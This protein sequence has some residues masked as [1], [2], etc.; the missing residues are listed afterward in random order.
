MLCIRRVLFCFVLDLMFALT[1]V[2]ISSIMS[3]VIVKLSSISCIPFVKLAPEAPGL[4]PI[5]FISRFLPIW[6]LFFG[7]YFHFQIFLNYFIFFQSLF[8]FS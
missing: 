7:F 6:V 2:S 8:A 4:V 5:V 1:E 3:S